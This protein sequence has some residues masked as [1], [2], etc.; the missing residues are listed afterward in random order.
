MKKLLCTAAALA[1][2]SLPAQAQEITMKPYVGI[3]LMRTSLSY[4]ESYN[5]G[6]GIVLNGESLLDDSLNGFN[7]HVGNRFHKNFGVELGYFRTSEGKKN[8]AAGATVGPGVVAAVPFT[9]KV[10]L[11]GFTL[12]ALG[13]LPVDDQNR[14]ELIGTAGLAWSKGEV[15]LSVPGIGAAGNDE[16]EFGFRLGGG[17]QFNFT[18]NVGIRGLARYQQADFEDVVD[19]EWVYSVGLNYSF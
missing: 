6:G 13:Y 12:D 19:R 1:A 14:F 5:A 8:I 17:A 18:D 9:S 4:N 7:I 3:D 16:S 15:E 10:K 11:S 2:I